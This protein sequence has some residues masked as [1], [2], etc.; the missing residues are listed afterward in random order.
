MIAKHGRFNTDLKD[1][2]SKV[3]ISFLSIQHTRNQVPRVTPSEYSPLQPAYHTLGEK[4]DYP[5]SLL[6]PLF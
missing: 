2:T 3:L 1:A 5:Y 6:T 4:T